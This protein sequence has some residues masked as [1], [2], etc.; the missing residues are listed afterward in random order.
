MIMRSAYHEKKKKKLKTTN[1]ITLCI[2]MYDRQLGDGV[3]KKNTLLIIPKTKSAHT[4]IRQFENVNVIARK[5]E[6]KQ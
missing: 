3:E 5:A 6:L 1:V 4:H 2:Y